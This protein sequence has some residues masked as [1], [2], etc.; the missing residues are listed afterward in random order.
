MRIG[1]TS[2]IIPADILTNVRWLAGRVQDVE[3][4]I[5]QC[6]E[7]GTDLPDA[8]CVAELIRIAAE[9]DVTYTIHLPLN[10]RLVEDERSVTTALRVIQATRDLKPSGYVVH[11]DGNAE[12]GSEQLKSWVAQSG[13]CLYRLGE[14]AGGLDLLCVENLDGQSPGM[15]DA[16]LEQTPVS[17]CIDVGHL[18]KQGL[19]PLP[20]LDAWLPRCRVVHLHG[21]DGTDHNALSS[22]S[23][24]MLD[25]VV[26]KLVNGFDGVVTLE[27]FSERDLEQSMA[28]LQG[29]IRRVSSHGSSKH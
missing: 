3:I 15:L 5:F 25:P 20:C 22:T 18:W 11:L 2:Y 27:I 23:D 9:H 7:L 8:E 13:T 19:D 6:D 12:P 21:V 28:A 1:T 29:S 17:C 24:E 14:A 26:E 4:V 16:V 10:L